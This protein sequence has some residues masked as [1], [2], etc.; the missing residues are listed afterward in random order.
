MHFSTAL[1][2]A[3][4]ENH[5]ELN[6][7]AVSQA[8]CLQLMILIGSTGYEFR[9]VLV[10]VY[11]YIERDDDDNVKWTMETLGNYEASMI[12]E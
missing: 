11:L 10:K 1:F 8:T 9:G 3:H 7:K 12:Y 2:E 4:G 6:A 5:Q